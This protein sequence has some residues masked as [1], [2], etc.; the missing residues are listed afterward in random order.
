MIFR[1]PQ[2]ERVWVLYSN[3][4]IFEQILSRTVLYLNACS[5]EETQLRFYLRLI[6]FTVYSITVLPFLIVYILYVDRALLYERLD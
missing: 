2:T 3:S 6:A 4:M 5:P 1:D